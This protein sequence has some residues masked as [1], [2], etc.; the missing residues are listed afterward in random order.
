MTKL[1]REFI[2]D[3]KP[4]SIIL[5][6]DSVFPDI[7]NEEIK[8]PKKKDVTHLDHLEDLIIR[9]GKEGF[10]T[11]E[12]TLKNTHDFLKGNKNAGFAISEKRDGAP[13]LVVGH[14]TKSGQ[15]FVGTK[16]FFNK[17]PKINFSDKDIE[18]NH[19]WKTI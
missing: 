3:Q 11:L 18:T 4:I 16:S 1:L 17:T 6:D 2:E 7:I 8:K 9:D 10:D 15:F 5:V 19:G 14:D 13:A 12:Q